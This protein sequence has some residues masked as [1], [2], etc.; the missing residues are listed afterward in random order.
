MSV[1]DNHLNKKCKAFS[2]NKI[3]F[4]YFILPAPW[5]YVKTSKHINFLS[6][7]N[8]DIKRDSCVCLQPQTH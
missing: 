4:L 1:Y 6:R 7:V 3:H 2:S 5:Y 8:I